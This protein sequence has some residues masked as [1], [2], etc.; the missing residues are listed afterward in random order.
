M[1][2]LPVV[3][4]AVAVALMRTEPNPD[5]RPRLILGAS[6]ITLSVLGLRHLWSGSPG[7]PD[8]RRRA[9]GFIGFA[10]G[11]PLSDGLT[12]W[13]AAPLLFIGFMFGLLLLTGTTIREVPVRDARHVRHPAASTSDYD[14]EPYDYADEF[15]DDVEA[16][17]G[18]YSDDASSVPDDAPP[19]WSPD[20]EPRPRCRTTFPP[21]PNPPPPVRRPRGAASA[22]GR[23]TSTTPWNWTGSS[24]APTRCRR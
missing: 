5:A 14:D 15:D 23:R 8:A 4:A 13:I 12:P 1:L 9:A 16:E 24:R 19:A 17:P 10:I 21:C 3:T 22:D 18:N 20:D 7:D 2:A 11:G 6:L